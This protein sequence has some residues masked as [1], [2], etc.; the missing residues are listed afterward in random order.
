MAGAFLDRRLGAWGI[1]SATA[2]MTG[3]VLPAA[4]ATLLL[5]ITLV[6]WM[7]LPIVVSTLIAIALSF[8][9]SMP[10]VMNATMQPLPDIAGAVGAAAGSVQMTAG[11]ASSGLVSLLYDGS[12]ALSMAVVMTL[13]SLAAL[14]SY[15]FVARPADRRPVG[16][17]QAQ[18]G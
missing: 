8:G 13:C 12:S 18:L 9:L 1:S 2:L 10:N 3:L 15:L 14:V 11:A 7:P 17:D 5:T 4:A 6:G 16:F